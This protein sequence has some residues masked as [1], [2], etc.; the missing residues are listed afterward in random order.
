MTLTPQEKLDL[1]KRGFSRRNF[2]KI[3]TDACC[4]LDAAVL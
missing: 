3:A 2:G 1:I 4:R